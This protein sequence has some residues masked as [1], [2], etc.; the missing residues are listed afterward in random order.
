MGGWEQSEGGG[1]CP[2]PSGRITTFE[3][4]EEAMGICLLTCMAPRR[5]KMV[6]DCIPCATELLGMSDGDTKGWF[7]PG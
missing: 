4:R 5:T 1:G 6:G 3:G 7:Y 2:S